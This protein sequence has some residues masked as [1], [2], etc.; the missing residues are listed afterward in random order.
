MRKRILDGKRLR[1]N[2]CI[3]YRCSQVALYL[4]TKTK[5]PTAF[6]QHNMNTVRNEHEGSIFD[7]K[8][9]EKA[10]RLRRDCLRMDYG[11]LDGAFST[12]VWWKM[13]RQQNKSARHLSQEPLTYN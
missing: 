5:P 1:T 13:P 4:L 3:D 7:T 10:S 9:A 6:I 12:S 8:T 11:K 2:C